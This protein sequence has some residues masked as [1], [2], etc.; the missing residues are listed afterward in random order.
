MLYPLAVDG[1]VERTIERFRREMMPFV[2]AA[3]V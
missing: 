1:P 2:G 3:G